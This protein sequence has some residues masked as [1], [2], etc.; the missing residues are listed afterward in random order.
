MRRPYRLLP[1]RA[2]PH[3]APTAA[4]VWRVLKPGGE[5]HFADWGHPANA[6][7]RLLFVSVQVLDGFANT[8]DNVEGKLIPLLEEAGFSEVT[9]HQ[10]FCT[11]YGT[12]A[13]YRAARR[14]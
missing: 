8:Q 4:E 9:Q 5:L 6:L 13:L 14:A 2:L 7:M 3:R 1:Y 11:I 10:T 12:L